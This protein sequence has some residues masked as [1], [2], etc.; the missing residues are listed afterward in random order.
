MSCSRLCMGLLLCLSSLCGIHA[1]FPAGFYHLDTYNGLSGNSIVHILQLDDDRMVFT[2][3]DGVNIYDGMSY[4]HYPRK[5]ATEYHLSYYRGA[6]HVYIGKND[7]LWIKNWYSLLL[8]DLRHERYISDP[9][10]YLRQLGIKE[11]VHDVFLDSERGV[12]AVAGDKVVNV[13]RRLA[14]PLRADYGVLQDVDVYG[15]N[16]YL[17]FSTGEVRC[18]S[19][20]DGRLIYVSAAY[21]KAESS[22]YK[23]FSL[24]VRGHD[25]CFYQKRGGDKSVCLSF[26]THTRQWKKLLE[27]P[28]TLHTI[29]LNSRTSLCISCGKGLWNIDL[30]TG[31]ALYQ[32]AL[33]MAEGGQV[34][35][36][37][38][39]VFRDRQGGWWLGTYDKGL[40][41]A[42]SLRNDDASTKVDASRLVLK[43]LLVGLS[44]NGNPLTLSSGDGTKL[45][46]ESIPYVSNLNFGSSQDNL[47]FT[48]S[49]LNYALPTHTVFRYRLFRNG[50]A[51]SQWTSPLQSTRNGDVSKR[52]TVTISFSDM[53][54]GDY[55]LQV[56]ASVDGHFKNAKATQIHFTIATPWW[57]TWWAYIIYAV[58]FIIV[59][60]GL[61]SIRKTWKERNDKERKLMQRVQELIKRC[62]QYEAMEAEDGGDT[63]STDDNAFVKK[64][65]AL[66]EDN[67]GSSYGVEQLSR[68]LCMERTGL[69]K[70]LSALLDQSPSMFIRS[71]RLRKAADMLV[72]TDK[73]VADISTMTGFSSPSYFSKCFQEEYGCR[74]SEYVDKH[75]KA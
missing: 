40:L 4:H 57:L 31:K 7:I 46:K 42:N 24:T 69:Y 54:H 11:T 63:L 74:P 51:V 14:I 45:L 36:Q 27:V 44:V 67:V 35:P 17:F 16:A 1:Q 34:V 47:S 19:L 52:G 21:P 28:Y 73:T 64:A 3:D 39:T 15:D 10:S 20:K 61:L 59:I 49:A 43:P 48:F 62:N 25:G 8:L 33:M 68:D 56:M 2:S 58:L 41:Y 65:I 6:Y 13:S 38:N 72:N 75:R 32:P 30:T 23:G 55:L 26:N 9:V 50:K 71:V 22:V 18:H 60:I 37:V 5:R 12:W 66:V 29:I 53:R 70:K